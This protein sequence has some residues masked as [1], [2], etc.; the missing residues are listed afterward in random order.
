LGV[1]PLYLAVPR[2]AGGATLSGVVS[3]P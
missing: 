1:S 3:P 2:G